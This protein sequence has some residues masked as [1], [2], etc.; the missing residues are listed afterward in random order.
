MFDKKEKNE[1]IKLNEEELMTNFEDNEFN[2]ELEKE[3]KK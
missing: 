3:E 2:L 1:E